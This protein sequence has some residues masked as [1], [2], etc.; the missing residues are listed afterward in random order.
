VS[1]SPRR[2]KSPLEVAAFAAAHLTVLDSKS[3]LD[4]EEHSIAQLRL[5]FGVNVSG[6]S[7]PAIAQLGSNQLGGFIE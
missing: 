1:A 3:P 7:P 2:R 4:P 5:E 6:L